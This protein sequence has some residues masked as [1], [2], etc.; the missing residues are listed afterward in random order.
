MILAS[1]PDLVAL[2]PGRFSIRFDATWNQG[3]GAFGG[4]LG[5]TIGKAIEQVSPG[6]PLRTLSMQMCAP[7]AGDLV[8]EVREE[9][10]GSATR[11][12]SARILNED[13]VCTL[14]TAML[15]RPRADDAD[16][17]HVEAPELP[18]PSVLQDVFRAFGG[19]P[20]PGVP[21]FTEHFEFR[22]ASG[23]PY[24]GQAVAHSTGWVRPRAPQ[25][26]SSHLLLALL[27]TW[28]LAVLPTLSRPRPV[29]SISIHQQLFPPFPAG[30][31]EAFYGVDMRSELNRD[32]Y[33]DQ[34]TSLFSEDG[35]LLG[36]S[37]Q[38]VAVIR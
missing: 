18:H 6:L 17:D 11:F 1:A 31:P 36:R 5:A 13:G 23:I 24:T 2:E 30:A 4:V 7:A 28:P 8:V 34:Q 37:T 33:V 29:A 3:R 22:M 38:L 26:L 32:G 9:R 14:A 16:F 20:M 19:G 12:F 10:Q 15:G 27:D 25:A 21:A 35:R